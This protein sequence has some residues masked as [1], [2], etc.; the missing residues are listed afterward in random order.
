[1][2]SVAEKFIK[3]PDRQPPLKNR[4]IW[5]WMSKNLFSSKLNIF[6][7]LAIVFILYRTIPPI[8]NW[9]FVNSDWIG[10]SNQD[11]SREGA[12]WVYINMKWYLYMYGFYP[13]EF[14]W[15]PNLAGILFFVFLIPFF[16]KSFKYKIPWLLFFLFGY[17]IIVFFILKGGTFGLEIVETTKWGG[18]MLTLF[19][20]Y[21]GILFAL[22]LGL[23]L[24]LGRSSHLTIAR[25]TSVM[26]IEFWRGVPLI[27]ILFMASN[28]FPLFFPTQLEVNKYLR[29]VIGIIFFQSAY[30]AEVIRGGLQAI[31]KGQLEASDSL[32]LSYW[33]KIFYIVLPQ[34][35]KIVIPSLVGA[36]ISL[37]KDTSLLLIIGIFDILTMVPVTSADSNW[38]G[39]EL[40]GYVFVALI[41]WVFCY[42]MSRY[43]VYLEERFSIGHK[44]V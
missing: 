23:I 34:A 16:I 38:L 44:K 31:P 26:F 12:C 20:A 24:A 5:L 15:R 21:V 1:M 37:F 17:P 9:L 28:V 22:P 4:G 2:N 35:I 19:T 43:S 7:T 8:Y 13:A 32:G 36:S 41:F 14:Y 25:F 3:M 6:I 29:A 18:L 40:E 27:T 33:E 42:S 11:C 39:F 10:T 30:V